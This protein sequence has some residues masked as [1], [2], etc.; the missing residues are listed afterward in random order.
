MSVSIGPVVDR[1]HMTIGVGGG[2]LYSFLISQLYGLKD[3]SLNLLPDG[4]FKL[5]DTKEYSKRL[6]FWPEKKRKTADITVGVTKSKHKYFKLG[7]YP[8]RFRDGDFDKI[9]F[10]LNTLFSDWS[11]EGLFS[12][13]RVSYIEIAHD[14]LNKDVALYLPYHPTARTSKFHKNSDGSKGSAYLGSPKSNKRY[15]VYDKAKQLIE[16]QGKSNLKKRMR[17]EARLRKTGLKPI[18]LVDGLENPF[19][20]LELLDVRKLV[21][22]SDEAAWVDFVQACRSVGTAGALKPCNKK[23]RKLYKARLE[24]AKVGWWDANHWWSKWPSAVAAI[25]P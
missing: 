1:I 9:K 19:Q 13:A 2:D 25:Q 17:V 3:S 23:L 10:I 4:K 22:L 14:F 11:Y 6:S 5:C 7:L 24:S 16:T 12:S 18:N 8:S 21:D 15:C 20:G